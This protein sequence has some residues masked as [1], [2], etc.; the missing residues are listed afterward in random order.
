MSALKKS[1]KQDLSR[2]K[3]KVLDQK[4]IELLAQR[5]EDSFM[6]FLSDEGYRLLNIESGC[7]ID[8][9]GI[10]KNY[11]VQSAYDWNKTKEYDTLRGAMKAS[12]N[13]L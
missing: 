10:D 5:M 7:T 2:H 13:G 9:G 6:N 12:E 11:T 3:G 1:F 4:L 8:A